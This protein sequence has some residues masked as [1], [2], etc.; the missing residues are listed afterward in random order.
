MFAFQTILRLTKKQTCPNQSSNYCQSLEWRI[1]LDLK[2]KLLVWINNQPTQINR[3]KMCSLRCK[4]CNPCNDVFAKYV[5]TQ[6][7]TLPNML[8]LTQAP[9][10]PFHK[11]SKCQLPLLKLLHL[12][13]RGLELVLLRLTSNWKS[14]ELETFNNHK[15]SWKLLQQKK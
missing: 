2:S 11:Q 1:K 9:P 13:W 15:V 7:S 10:C 12:K 3:V 14:V 8:G 4:Y 5:S 6:A